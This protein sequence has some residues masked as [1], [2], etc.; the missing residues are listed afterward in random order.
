MALRDA[1]SEAAGFARQKRDAKMALGDAASDSE[2]FA[3]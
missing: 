1:A 3:R 2:G